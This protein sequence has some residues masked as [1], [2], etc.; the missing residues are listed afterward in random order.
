VSG[1]APYPRSPARACALVVSVGLLAVTACKPSEKKLDQLASATAPSSPPPVIDELPTPSGS[2]AEDDETS[3]R[4]MELLKARFTSEVKNREP[5]DDLK[6]AQ[7]GKRTYFH[8]TLRNRTGRERK[9]H[10]TF[11]VNDDKRTELD[12]DVAESWSFRTWGYNTLRSTDKSGKLRVTVE[13]DEGYPVAD[14]TLPI[15]P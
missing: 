10:V 4:P 2:A 6:V 9:V 11:F 14:M 13:D 5:V 7:A 3:T 15:A 8:L 12:L 1:V